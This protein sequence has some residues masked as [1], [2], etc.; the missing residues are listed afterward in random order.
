[1]FKGGKIPPDI[2]D[3]DYISPIRVD[4]DKD[5]DRQRHIQSRY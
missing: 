4:A 5:N 1:M 2:A 3:M